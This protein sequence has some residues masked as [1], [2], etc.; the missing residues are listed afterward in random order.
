MPSLFELLIHPASLTVIAMYVGLMLWEAIF[1]ARKLPFVPYWRV[2]GLVSFFAYF[3]IS[4]YLPFVWTEQLAAWQLFDLTSLGTIGGAVV[5]V[6][7]YEAGAYIWHRSMHKSHFLWRGFHQ[8]HHSAE[9]IDVAGTFWFSPLDMIGWTA[10]SSLC[11]TLV[12]GLTAEATM[13][14]IYFITFLAIFQHA[15]IRTPVWLGY[16]V[17]RPESHSHHHA[18]GVHAN[19]YAD[20][21]IFDLIFGTFKNPKDYA[22]ENG[23]YTGG[24]YRVIDMLRFKDVSSPSIPQSHD[25][26]N[27]VTARH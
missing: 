9:R 7:V 26:A 27:V 13:I 22:D 11:L 4:S 10:L 24:T 25:D 12:V 2:A 19:N 8:M 16:L 15:N 17:Q 3:L 20:L 6:F 1:P 23:F 14:A 21:P 5:G 18:R